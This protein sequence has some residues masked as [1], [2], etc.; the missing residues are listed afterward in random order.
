MYS[1]ATGVAVG[2][3]LGIAKLVLGFDSMKRTVAPLCGGDCSHGLVDR[4]VR[5]RGLG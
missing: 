2:I 5:Q 3:S 4:G 1:V